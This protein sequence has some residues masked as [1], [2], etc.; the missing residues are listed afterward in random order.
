M[1]ILYLKILNINNLKKN[2]IIFKNKLGSY[3]F[4]AL[5]LH[6]SSLKDYSYPERPRELTL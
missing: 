5:N 6:S 2:L 4:Y 1:K 3:V